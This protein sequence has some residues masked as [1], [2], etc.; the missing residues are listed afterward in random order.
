MTLIAIDGPAG[1]GKSTIARALAERLD[2]ARLD[3]GAMYR[4]VTLLVLEAGGDP[5]SDEPA[6]RL[7]RDMTLDLGERVLLNGRDVTAAIRSAAVDAAV[8]AVS[9]HPSVREELVSRQR[10]WAAQHGGGVVE[11]RDIGSVVFPDAD[12][13]VFLTAAPAVRAG[14]RVRERGESPEGEGREQTEL[15]EI[16]RR[17]GLDSSRPVSPLEIA[18]GALIVDSTDLGVDEVVEEV[19]RNL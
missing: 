6:T 8:S 4:A 3:T 18:E 1:A 13:K 10:R 17:D 15:A 12:L 16:V 7:A 9:S 19:L 14:R 2:L 5:H 11:G